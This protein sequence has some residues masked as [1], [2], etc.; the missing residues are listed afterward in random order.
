MVDGGRLDRRTSSRSGNL[1]M[2]RK[3]MPDSLLP[4]EAKA[5]IWRIFGSG[6]SPL[7]KPSTYDLIKPIIEEHTSSIDTNRAI[8]HIPRMVQVP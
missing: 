5:V 4:D 2:A 6:E 3:I 1:L 7:T 8:A